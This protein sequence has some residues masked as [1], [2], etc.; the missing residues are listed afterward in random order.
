VLLAKCY[1]E[2]GA[3]VVPW[4]VKAYGPTDVGSLSWTATDWFVP[5]HCMVKVIEV[6]NGKTTWYDNGLVGWLAYLWD[7]LNVPK[8]KG[9][10]LNGWPFWP[11]TDSDG[12]GLSDND[13][14]CPYD[15]YNTCP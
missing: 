15:G 8:V 2:A 7:G 12:D 9:D 14:P 3:T 13:D 6:A 10:G 4:G 11:W 1:D 5:H